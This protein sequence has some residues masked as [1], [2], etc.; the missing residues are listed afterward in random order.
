MAKGVSIKFASYED[1]VPRLLK[2]IKFDE[3]LKKHE[4]IVLKPFVSA[5]PEESTPAAFV[6]AVVSF[7]VRNKNPESRLAIAEGADGVNTEDAFASLGY[8]EIAENYGVGLI[9]LNQTQCDELGN[10]GFLNFDTIMYP[11]LLRESFV[12]SMPKLRKDAQAEMLGS[13]ANMLGAFPA[14]H[15]KGF[16]SATKSKLKNVPM[17]YRIH[18]IIACKMPEFALIDASAQGAIIAGKPLESDKQAAR[19][20]GLST[21]S[22]LKLLEE[23]IAARAPQETPL[24]GA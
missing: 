21:V 2:L 24:E 17:K 23:S 4:S 15:Y 9:D 12:I 20:L 5:N 18:D 10:N 3:E 22:H 1:T 13:L 11:T 16:F 8:R 14:Q 19:A 7:C 6:E